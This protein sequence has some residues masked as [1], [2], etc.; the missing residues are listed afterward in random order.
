MFL[1]IL[2]LIVLMMAV[3][4]VNQHLQTVGSTYKNTGQL[5]MDSV[6]M[7]KFDSVLTQ[8]YKR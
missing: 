3:W 1:A 5:K 7:V 8:T 4:G 6:I 2:K